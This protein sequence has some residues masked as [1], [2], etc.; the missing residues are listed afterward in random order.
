MSYELGVNG[1]QCAKSMFAVAAVLLLLLL[2]CVAYKDLPMDLSLGKKIMSPP[3][4]DEFSKSLVGMKNSIVYGIRKTDGLLMVIEQQHIDQIHDLETMQSM[5]DLPLGHER[6]EYCQVM[7]LEYDGITFMLITHEELVGGKV[8][9]TVYHVKEFRRKIHPH[10]HSFAFRFEL[11]NSSLIPLKRF[12]D[13]RGTRHGFRAFKERQKGKEPG[14]AV[15]EFNT[16]TR[17]STL[18]FLEVTYKIFL[19][20]SPQP[21]EIE[22]LM[23]STPV[24]FGNVHS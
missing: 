4:P 1:H 23:M 5:I 18:Y 17:A 14:F 9:T 22:L 20:G 16:E 13:E 7:L 10:E 2:Q 19:F 6:F 21:E 8:L 3:H 15:V 11:Y 24:A 12:S